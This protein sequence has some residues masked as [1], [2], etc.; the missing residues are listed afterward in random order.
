MLVLSR[1]VGERLVI[2]ED[3]VLV[4]NKVAGNRVVIAIDAPSN[5]RIVRGELAPL[6]ESQSA[7]TDAADAVTLAIE[8]RP[9]VKSNGHP[10]AVP[11]SRLR[12]ACG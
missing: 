12:A 2:G 4:V 7:S 6:A 11:P 1:K 8:S 5:V 9:S 10:S 3:I